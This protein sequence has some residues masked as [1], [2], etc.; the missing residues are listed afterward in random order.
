MSDG[1]SDGLV[2]PFSG[3]VVGERSDVDLPMSEDSYEFG[4]RQA[5]VRARGVHVEV[6]LHGSP[7]G[8]PAL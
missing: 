8:L 6:Y 5:S 4:G 7:G 3:V 1:G 2:Q